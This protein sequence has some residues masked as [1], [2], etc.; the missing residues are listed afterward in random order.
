MA[1]SITRAGPKIAITYQIG[2]TRHTSV[3]LSS[4]ANSTT[5]AYLQVRNRAVIVGTKD[6][7]VI[8]TMDGTGSVRLIYSAARSGSQIIQAL[9]KVSSKYVPRG[10]CAIGFVLGK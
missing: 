10:I 7:N 3:L 6:P 2:E 8:R 1:I 5:P 4:R 9:P